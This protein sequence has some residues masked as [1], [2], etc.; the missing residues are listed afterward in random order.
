MNLNIGII[1]LISKMLVSLALKNKEQL[2]V[3]LQYFDPWL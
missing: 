1:N 2:F 3:Y